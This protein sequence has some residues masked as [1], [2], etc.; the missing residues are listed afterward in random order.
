MEFELGLGELRLQV[1]IL[2][3]AQDALLVQFGD[4]GHGNLLLTRPEDR[5]PVGLLGQALG[6][7]L[8]PAAALGLVDFGEEGL[9][10]GAQAG[11]VGRFAVLFLYHFGHLYLYIICA[12]Y[13]TT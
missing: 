8:A 3:G 6:D 11:Q 4:T 13:I 7:E 12:S 5:L 9:V 10:L 1:P 2:L